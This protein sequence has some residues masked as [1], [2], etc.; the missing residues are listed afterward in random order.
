M[1][2]GGYFGGIFIFWSLLAIALLFGFAYIIWVLASKETG[3]IKLAGQIISVAIA[4]LVVILVLYGLIYG[5]RMK[6][7][8]MMRMGEK[9]RGEMMKEMM[10]NPEMRKM[11]KNR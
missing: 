2:M 7:P 8:G 1:M 10:K 3:G 5:G 11:M 4:V 6:G 9:E